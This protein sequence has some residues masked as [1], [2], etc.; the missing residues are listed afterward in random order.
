MISVEADAD[1][2]RASTRSTWYQHHQSYS[3][4][5]S[6]W[7]RSRSRRQSTWA[8]PAPLAATTLTQTKWP[9]ESAIFDG[10]A[11]A[12]D[13]HDGIQ[14]VFTERKR[15]RWRQGPGAL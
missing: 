6:S 13:G 15:G 10:E 5:Y 8:M 11:C 3:R 14:A 2:Q 12:G 9:F 7:I 1:R 4:D